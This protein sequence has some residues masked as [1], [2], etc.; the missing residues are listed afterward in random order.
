DLTFFS[1]GEYI[2]YPHVPGRRMQ[3]VCLFISHALP[4]YGHIGAREIS[5]T[6]R[7]HLSPHRGFVGAVT[8][9]V[10]SCAT[11]LFVSL[12]VNRRRHRMA[13]RMADKNETVARL[14][15]F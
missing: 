4:R 2:R 5:P 9:F 10:V 14:V 6:D 3:L 13:H 15:H 7:I 12:L 8:K 11:E 1:A